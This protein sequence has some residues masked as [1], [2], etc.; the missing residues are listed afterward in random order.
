FRS[1]FPQAIRQFLV[2]DEFLEIEP[3][4]LFWYDPV[5]IG[6]EVIPHGKGRAW[7]LPSGPVVLNQYIKGGQ[8]DRFFQFLRVTRREDNPTPQHQQEH[9]SLDINMSYVDVPDFQAQV[10]KLLAHAVKETTGKVLQTPFPSYSF[11]EA[12]AKFGTDRPDVRFGMEIAQ[13]LPGGRGFRAIGA[14]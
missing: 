11:A 1:E 6:G 8:F 4:H 14:G 5:A 9:T 2:G 10:E 7:R 3:R 13:D 12:M